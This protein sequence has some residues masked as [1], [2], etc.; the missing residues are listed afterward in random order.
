MVN[1]NGK[2]DDAY[3]DLSSKIEALN[4]TLKKVEVEVILTGYIVK[5]HERYI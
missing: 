5:R 1:F 4:A 2:I 3:T